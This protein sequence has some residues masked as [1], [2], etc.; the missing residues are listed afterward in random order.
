MKSYCSLDLFV[1]S[2]FASWFVGWSGAGV[3]VGMLTGAATPL[4]EKCL[5]FWF[6]ERIFEMFGARLSNNFKILDFHNYE[7]YTNNIL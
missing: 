4:L 5:V 1:L 3:G 7:I 6:L 2:Q